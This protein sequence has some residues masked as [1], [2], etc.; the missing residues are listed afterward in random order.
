MQLAVDQLRF[1]Y[2]QSRFVLAI[3]E[4][5]IA[6]A[7]CVALVGPSGCGKSTLLKL[8]CG[9]LLPQQGRVVVGD[10]AM[11]ALNDAERRAFRIRGLGFVFQDF[12][13]LDYLGVR[14]NIL[15]PGRLSP[16]LP[17][18]AVLRSRVDTLAAE[19]GISSLLD[20]PVAQLSQGERQRVAICRALVGGPKL[21]FADEPTGNLDPFNKSRIFELLLTRARAAHATLVVV[22]HDHSFLDRFDRTLSLLDF[23]QPTPA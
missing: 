11:S 19:T 14:E 9:M 15:L 20:R 22:T 12:A 23:I 8:L 13:L 3:D 16:S 7:E 18:D 2:P 10:A 1:S 21:I 17:L 6:D 4:L 5:R